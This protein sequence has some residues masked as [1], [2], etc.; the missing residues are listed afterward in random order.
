MK[1]AMPL[2]LCFFLAFSGLAYSQTQCDR[3]QVKETGVTDALLILI[4]QSW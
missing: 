1:T 3:T 2:C 4:T